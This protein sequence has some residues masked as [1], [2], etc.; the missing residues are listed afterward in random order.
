MTT[1]IIINGNEVTNPFSRALLIMSAILIIALVTTVVIFILLPL[2]GI[3]VT[4]SIGFV[5]IFIIAAVVSV[6]SLALMMALSGK[7][8][9]TT[10]FRIERI[11]RE[12]H[13]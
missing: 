4:L 8:F 7:F 9:G 6:V 12:S 10:D 5:L 3:A 11:Y 2:I 13:D 1:R